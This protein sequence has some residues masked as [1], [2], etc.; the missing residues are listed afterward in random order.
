MLLHLLRRT[1][2]AA[3]AGLL[4]LSTTGCMMVSLKS[5]MTKPE[6]RETVVDKDP[7]WLTD[8]K[9]LL[10]DIGGIIA[11]ERGGGL[12][13]LSGVCCTPDYVKSVLNR[14]KRD[15]AVRAVILRIDS[16]GGTVGASELI[17]REV[18][19]F[20][21]ETRIPVYA[22][23]TGLGCSGGYYVAA[24]AEKIHIQK[25]GITGSIGVIASLPNFRKLADKVG[26]DQTVV[27]SGAMKDIGSAMRAMTP[28]ERAVFQ[29][30]IDSSYDQFLAWIVEN[31]PQLESTEKLKP[32][33]DGRIY[34]ADQALANQLVDRIAFLDE[35]IAAVKQAAHLTAADVV[36][37]GYDEPGDPN[38]Y[39]HAS[40]A[41][42]GIRLFN[43]ELPLPSARP[44][45]YYLWSTGL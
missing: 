29:T 26:Y 32:I 15:P 7:H 21:A 1:L 45:F 12:F 4:A 17:A 9:V 33:A 35:T 11:E 30:M 43:A 25:S 27:K 31:R 23:I 40:A 14:A 39:T 37:Y 34:T 6:L 44:G 2:P 16:P 36:I 24:A 22:Q 28:E 41:G 10:V 42:S 20:R 19:L 38:I 3:A 18:R 8:G 13:S 5:L